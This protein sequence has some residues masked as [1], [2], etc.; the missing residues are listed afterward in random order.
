[1]SAKPLRILI[2]DDNPEDRETCRRLL[3][4]ANKRAFVVSEADC[5]EDGLRIC[6]SSPPDC[7]LLDYNLPDVDGLEFLRRLRAQ[8][9]GSVPVVF[10]TGAGNEMV[11][12]TSIKLGAH[13]YLVKGG[14]PGDGIRRAVFSAIEKASLER[15]IERQR[16]ELQKQAT[17]LCESEKELRR[18]LEQLRSADR[19]KDEFLAMLGHE[20]RNPLGSMRMDVA[21]LRR[22]ASTAGVQGESIGRLERQVIHMTRLVDDL[23]DISRLVRGRIELRQEPIEFAA[24]VEEALATSRQQIEARR[25]ELSISLPG[26]PVY[27]RGDRE[28]LIQVM[29]NLL[30]NAAKYTD[31]GGRI[32]LEGR[33]AAAQAP[34][35]PSSEVDSEASR[36]AVPPEGEE[37]IIC[38]RDNGRGIAPEFLPYVFDVFAQSD[39]TLDRSQGGLGIGLTL[40]KQLVELHDGSVEAESAGLG[41]GSEFIVRLPLLE[42]ESLEAGQLRK[43]KDTAV[44]FACRILVIDDNDP[45]RESMETLLRLD[46]YDVRLAPNGAAALAEAPSFRPHVALVDIGLPNM[47]GFEVARRLR[48]LPGG[49]HILLIALTGYGDQETRS[50]CEAAGFDAHMVKPANLETLSSMIQSHRPSVRDASRG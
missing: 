16:E 49:E 44:P 42:R 26:D 29:A 38:V 39:R 9:R 24:L 17:E 25:H 3:T 37:L 33:L 18:L 19:R 22:V 35:Q 5:G 4:T 27:L 36:Q 47:N 31:I 1:M 48:G 50:Q 45:V 14:L 15:E 7:V 28:R 23:L 13:D 20:L 46:N 12:A 10:L 32:W 43:N 11:A 6:L 8:D 21:V 30:D 2:V 41:R 34:A 40:V